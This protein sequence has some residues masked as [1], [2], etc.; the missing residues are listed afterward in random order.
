MLPASGGSATREDGQGRGADIGD[1]CT[2]GE[3]LR[4]CV[5][6]PLSLRSQQQALLIARMTD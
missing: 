2:R 3:W 1:Q 4:R 5:T 6:Q